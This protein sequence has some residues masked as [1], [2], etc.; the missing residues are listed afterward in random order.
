M[1]QPILLPSFK[2]RRV[3][4][5]GLARSGLAAA[6]VLATSGADVLAWDDGVGGQKAAEA[7][8]IPLTNLH[9]ADLSGVAALVL[10]PGIPHTFP[11]PHPVAARAKAAGVPIIGDVEL[12]RLAQPDA[13][14]VGITGTNGKSTTTALTGHILAHAGRTL[15]VGGNLGI[16]VLTFPALVAGDVYVL[17]MSSYQLELTPSLGFD[18]AVLLNITPDHLDRHGGMD[19]YIAAKRLI[20]QAG[21]RDRSKPPAIAILGVDEPNTAAMAD[22]L[23]MEGGRKVVRISSERVVPGGVYAAD[24]VLV[25]DTDGQARAVVDLRQ[26]AALPG[27]HNWQNA[28]AAYAATRA[29]GVTPEVIAEAM[30]TFPGLVHRQQTI[31]TLDGIRFVNDSKA[32]NAD[33]ASKA[34]GCY[35]DMYWI[36][37]GKAKEGGLS[38][39][40]PFMGRVRHAF[41][42]GEA[43]E[44]FAPWL[45][46]KVSYGR[47]GTL[48]Q[49]VPAAYAMAREAMKANGAGGTV[50]LSPACASFDQYPNFEVRGD[51]FVRIVRQLAGQLETGKDGT[52]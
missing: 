26:C 49:A 33:A 13:A 43:T 45:E 8:G 14:Y 25:D 6:R 24:G 42:I 21:A 29:V 38:G 40:E 30:R 47:Y 1:S 2:G 19:G 18:A 5:M 15:A 52:P 16:P 3:A 23:E 10:S 48:D 35:E 22:S 51:A 12:L 31:A 50:L 46:G 4:V 7:A 44:E 36:V 20:F 32:T 41:L 11:A 39:L 27:R 17:E 28:C 9:E 37:G 34:L